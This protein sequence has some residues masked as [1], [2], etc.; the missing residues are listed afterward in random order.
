MSASPRH[1]RGKHSIVT[2]ATEMS[3]TRVVRGKRVVDA[4][5]NDALATDRGAGKAVS[6]PLS[7]IVQQRNGLFDCHVASQYITEACGGT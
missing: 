3:L 7:R 1:N 5:N 4:S 2:L 6:E